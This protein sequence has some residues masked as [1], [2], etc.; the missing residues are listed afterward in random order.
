MIRVQLF[1]SI[2]SFVNASK[3]Y[4]YHRSGGLVVSES[5]PHKEVLGSN[6]GAFTIHM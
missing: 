2:K 6:P 1:I 5:R 4:V 3:L